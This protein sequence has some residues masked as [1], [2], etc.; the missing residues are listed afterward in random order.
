M[1]ENNE[2]CI[3]RAVAV[4]FVRNMT[5]ELFLGEQLDPQQTAD[6]IECMCRWVLTDVDEIADELLD[7]EYAWQSQVMF[8]RPGVRICTFRSKNWLLSFLE[9]LKTRC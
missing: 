2:L 3:L 9:G 8:G 4:S 5:A 6:L 7:P 1:A